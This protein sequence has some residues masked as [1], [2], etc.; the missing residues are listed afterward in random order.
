[1][2]TLRLLIGSDYHCTPHLLER[3]LDQIPSCD[4][5]INCGDFCSQA[6][7]KHKASDQGFHPKGKAEVELLKTFLAQVDRLGKPW[8]FVPGNHDPSGSVIEPLA[9][10]YGVIATDTQL[11]SFLG[12]RTLLVPWTPPCGWNWTLTSSRLKEILANHSQTSADLVI[13]HA[14]PRGVLDEKSKWYHRRTPTLRPL[15]EAIQ[16]RYYLCGHMHHDGG[17]QLTQGNTLFVN[18]AVHNLILDVEIPES[19]EGHSTGDQVDQT[20]AHAD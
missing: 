16:P 2:A 13:T 7:A 1:M 3:A 20:I 5:Y 14:P 8:I 12:L 18:A 15:V 11:I 6:G 9:G 19:L 4:G 10:E 17:Q